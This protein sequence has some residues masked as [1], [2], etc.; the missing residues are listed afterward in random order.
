VFALE[1]GIFLYWVSESLGVFIIVF[2]D[3]FY[4]NVWKA[5]FLI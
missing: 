1:V 3:S 4:V 5:Q 2:M